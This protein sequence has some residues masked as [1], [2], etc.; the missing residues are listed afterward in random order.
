MGR[1]V[2]GVVRRA[3]YDS[4]YDDDY[5]D[6][7]PRS[8]RKRNEYRSRRG[9]GGGGE[10]RG[11]EGRSRARFLLDVRLPAKVCPLF[12]YV[13]EEE[14]VWKFGGDACRPG[15][16]GGYSGYSSGG[17]GCVRGGGKAGAGGGSADSR[18]RSSN[19]NC[20]SSGGGPSKAISGGSISISSDGGDGDGG[21]RVDEDH[22]AGIRVFHLRTKLT[23][24][25]TDKNKIRTEGRKSNKES[26]GES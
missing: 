26:V 14:G 2:H 13:T 24:I 1:A 5:Q 20:N 21:G 8:R 9:T 16:Y 23:T 11:R 17:G 19:C 6:I 25:N 4:N 10:R 7:P 15:G 22:L 12:G 18:S 3:R